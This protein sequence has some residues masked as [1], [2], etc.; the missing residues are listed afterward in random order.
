MNAIFLDTSVA[1][2]LHP[3]KKGSPQRVKYEAHMAGMVLALSF[4]SA[5]DYGR[6]PSTGLGANEKKRA[7]RISCAN[8]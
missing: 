2:L 8:F 5:A 1:S 6:G 7:W 4:Q 3:K